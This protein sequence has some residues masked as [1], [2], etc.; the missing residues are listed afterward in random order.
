MLDR[1]ET[2][3]PPPAP[4]DSL[5]VWLPDSDCYSERVPRVLDPDLE[6]EPGLWLATVTSL[7]GRDGSLSESPA[8][9]ARA[10]A[11]RRHVSLRPV[12]RRRR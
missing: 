3:P 2:V 8:P 6:S 1:R 4:T 10:V 5:A 11:G 7:P 9:A 12:T